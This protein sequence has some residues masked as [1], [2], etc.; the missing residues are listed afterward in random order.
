LPNELRSV[1]RL[2]APTEI[3]GV[4]SI[5]ALE[6]PGVIV[7]GTARDRLEPEALLRGHLA[8][9]LG[10]RPEEL[11]FSRLGL[12][13]PFVSSPAGARICFSLSHCDDYIAVASAA[14]YEIGVDVEPLDRCV[15]DERLATKY[16]TSLE[17]SLLAPLP[18]SERSAQFLR[19]WA[20]KEAISKAAGLG[21]IMD[22]SRI[23]TS[24]TRLDGTLRLASP[25]GRHVIAL[26]LQ[27]NES[28]ESESIGHAR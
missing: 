19:F 25:D 17:R 3:P 1:E 5:T 22:F 14:E 28:P 15:D 23:E 4:T 16:C 27:R 8:Y 2:D 9:R 20:M 10:S 12:G 21:L 7:W 26:A 24:R 18:Q 11:A 6:S 13:K